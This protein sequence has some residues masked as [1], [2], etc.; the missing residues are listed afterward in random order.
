MLRSLEVTLSLHSLVNCTQAD[1]T[2][3]AVRLN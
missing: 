1:D 3:V 2:I